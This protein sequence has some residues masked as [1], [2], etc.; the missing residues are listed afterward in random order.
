M[1][2]IN[3]EM[4]RDQIRNT[5]C[6]HGI[7]V[8]SS[9]EY[10]INVGQNI[11]SKFVNEGGI[12]WQNP[13]TIHSLIFFTIDEGSLITDLLTLNADSNNGVLRLDSKLL[14][15]ALPLIS[16]SLAY[17][18]NMSLISCIVPFDWNLTRITP[19]HKNSEAN[20][21]MMSV[22]S[23]KIKLFKKKPGSLTVNWIRWELCV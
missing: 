9:N 19:I 22:L 13:E 18:F 7:S 2:K 4:I 16:K 14:R 17:Q 1:G 15:S 8:S 3:D 11:S 21:R 6:I 12:K 10:Y 23:H 5:S 20:Y